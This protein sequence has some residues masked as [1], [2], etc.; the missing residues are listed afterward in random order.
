MTRMEI[1]VSDFRVRA[2]AGLYDEYAGVARSIEV[3]FLNLRV[4]CN[5]RLG[6]LG[7][8]HGS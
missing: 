8:E 5:S 6:P 3:A 1:E 7:G 4:E 2:V